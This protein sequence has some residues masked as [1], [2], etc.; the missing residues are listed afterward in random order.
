MIETVYVHPHKIHGRQPKPIRI[1]SNRDD[2]RVQ[3]YCTRVLVNWMFEQILAE[4]RQKEQA[5]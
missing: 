3:E 4:Q 5:S 2:P 1:S